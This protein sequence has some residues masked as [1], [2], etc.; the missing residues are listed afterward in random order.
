M[1]MLSNALPADETR[2]C[3][4]CNRELTQDAF[5]LFAGRLSCVCKECVRKKKAATRAANEAKP[6][7]VVNTSFTKAL[8]QDTD[9]EFAGMHPND[10]IAL[11]G[12]AKK[13]LQERGF[14]V[15][16]S[17]SYTITKPIKFS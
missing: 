2:V 15:H 1:C 10:V 8:T 9:G 12:R 6:V 4:E 16:L 14:E 13:W 11:M 17:G 5:S 7:R 3:V